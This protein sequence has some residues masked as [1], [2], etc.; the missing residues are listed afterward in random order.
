MRTLSVALPNH[1]ILE[2]ASSAFRER[3]RASSGKR[4]PPGR[5]GV[6]VRESCRKS[7]HLVP[8]E[9]RRFGGPVARRSRR[10]SRFRPEV[11]RLGTGL[12]P[13]SGLLFEAV[14]RASLL[15][16]PTTEFARASVPAVPGSP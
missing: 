3:V 5:R 16:R 14:L 9:V 7:G 4:G 1:N 6:T 11:V 12:L 2:V 10:Y 13:E 15:P 8:R